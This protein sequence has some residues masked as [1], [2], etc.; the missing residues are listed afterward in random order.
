MTGWTPQ[1]AALAHLRKKQSHHLNQPIGHMLGVMV[2]LGFSV[3]QFGFQNTMGASVVIA[4]LTFNFVN[5]ERFKSWT[6]WSK[7]QSQMSAK[8]SQMEERILQSVAASVDPLLRVKMSTPDIT[9]PLKNSNLIPSKIDYIHRTR[10]LTGVATAVDTKT[11]IAFCVTYIEAGHTTTYKDSKLRTKIVQQPVFE[12]LFF[13]ADSPQTNEAE[14][15][16]AKRYPKLPFTISLKDQTAVMLIPMETN[17]FVIRDNPDLWPS[18]LDRLR[19]LS[20]LTLNFLRAI[21]GP[22]FSTNEAA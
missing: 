4:F 22:V 15:N 14:L 9:W 21:A 20:E 16:L 10:C 19:D 3:F 5:R 18:E 13:V 11:E 6:N 12:G 7:S 8:A 1:L 17:P 2:I